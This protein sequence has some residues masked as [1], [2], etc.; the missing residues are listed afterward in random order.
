M[1]YE[2]EK[3]IFPALWENRFFWTKWTKGT[4]LVVRINII[5]DH[6]NR[7]FGHLWTPIYRYQ[8]CRSL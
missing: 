3:A 1:D 7:P 2:S 6:G 4:V 8:S 5:Y